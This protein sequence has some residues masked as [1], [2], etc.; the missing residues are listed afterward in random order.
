MPTPSIDAALAIKG[1]LSETPAPE[2]QPHWAV[3]HSQS[4]VVSDELARVLRSESFQRS[5]RYCQF[6]SYIVE[7]TLRGKAGEINEITLA[8]AVFGRS[9]SGFDA[10]RDPIVRVEAARLRDKLARYYAG[11]GANSRMRITIPKGRYRP[12]F[13][14]QRDEADGAPAH[15]SGMR[16]ATIAQPTTTTQGGLLRKA[17]LHSDDEQARDCYYRGRYAAQQRDASAYVEAIQ[18]LR[19]AIVIDQGFA[20]AHAEL[21]LVLVDFAGFG[22]AP[23]DVL[24]AEARIAARRAIALDPTS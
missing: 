14:E 8:A 6:L 20:Q 15:G 21:A 1:P 3:N 13:I 16:L 22:F 18:L 5:Q 7:Q 17:G 24:S 9:A 2:F 4:A 11:D 10:Q 19:K 12:I 23:S